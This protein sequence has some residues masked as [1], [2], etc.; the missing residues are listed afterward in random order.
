MSIL[1]PA[2]VLKKCPQNASKMPATRVVLEWATFDDATQA[3]LVL[4][5]QGSLK[6]GKGSI[7]LTSLS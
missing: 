4:Y 6:E 2:K 1:I 5:L 7:Q 3:G